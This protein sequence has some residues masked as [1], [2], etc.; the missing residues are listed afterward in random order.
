MKKSFRFF[1]LIT[2]ELLLSVL[3]LTVQASN[4]PAH[5]GQW[6]SS[7]IGG[8]GYLQ[9]VVMCPSNPERLYTYVDVGG[10][11]RSDDGG[12]RWK[13]LHGALPPRKGTYEVRG[14]TVDPRDEDKI[15]IAVG[16][17]WEKWKGG[18]F[19]SHDGGESFEFAVEISFAGNGGH[20][21]DGFILTRQP[22]NPDITLAGAMRDGVY[23]SE[24]NG[25]TWSASGLM[26]TNIVD[27]RFDL[28]NP[29]RV[30]A[31]AVPY[32]GWLNG[33]PDQ[34]LDG[35]FYESLDAG[36]HWNKI[37][38]EAVREIIQDPCDSTVLYGLIN[39]TVHRSKNGG[40]DWT[41]FAKGLPPREGN[42]HP[43]FDEFKALAVG[44]DFVLTASTKGAVF[45]KLKC[46]TDTWV[47]IKN[48]R[49]EATY[50]GE[51]WFHHKH[52]FG[53]ALGSI[54]VDF[55]NP[56]RWFFTDWYAIHQTLDEGRHWELAIDGIEVTVIHCL[57]Q[58]LANP[59]HIH[60]GMADNG[61]FYS[62]NGG[63]RFYQNKEGISNNI[64]CIAIA[65][66]RPSRMYAVGPRKWSWNANQVFIS[67]NRG[68]SWARPAMKGLP[69]MKHHHCNS[70][71]V[72][73][74]DPD[75]V[76]LTVSQT[77]EPDKGGV[78]KSNDAGKTWSWMGQGLEGLHF[79]HS[80]WTIGRELAMDKEGNL[81]CI[82]RK[83]GKAFRWDKKHEK[84]VLLK[85]KLGG[86][87]C[88]VAD[89]NDTGLFFIGCEWGNLWRT[90]D[91]GQ[92]WQKV[93]DDPTS[94]VAIDW[95]KPNRIVAGCRDRVM[96]SDD[97]G[98]S[99]REIDKHLPHPLGCVVGFC[100]DR[101]LAGSKGS[102]V[103]WIPIPSQ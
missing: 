54:T 103:F 38:D 84:W 76:Y 86:A 90:T 22:G 4:E 10:L 42:D 60:L 88:I 39:R 32:K 17:H 8:G 74:Q 49:N 46:G 63:E 29:K 3:T 7:K 14:L 9:N 34:A 72:S 87:N 12:Q 65:P 50:E 25:K 1:C 5:Y 33:K 64:K 41:L 91:A 80:I 59:K 96:I 62:E 55:K 102:G 92:S 31:C 66:S 16:S 95:A 21:S 75:T 19:T 94:H 73:P 30:W 67:N 15:V 61:Y 99:W 81:L 69:D 40:K 36:E 57:Q 47:K 27:L 68:K 82:L 58:D 43:D 18:L 37:S 71:V 77:I 53:A 78:Y 97:T 20:R 79:H 35:G 45:Y 98:D 101:V 13:M 52:R 70:I 11:Y 26:D 83:A 44:P 93:L 23:R 100:G 6:R 89:P 24:D 48:E 85:D 56:K 51:P 28:E 2:L